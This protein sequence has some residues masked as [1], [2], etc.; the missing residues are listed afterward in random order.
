MPS[1]PG[2]E[3]S[4]RMIS[5][6]ELQQFPDEEFLGADDPVYFSYSGA[7]E[8]THLKVDIRRIVFREQQS[9]RFE[10]RC[11]QTTLR[12]IPR[13]NCRYASYKGITSM[14]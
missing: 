7:A 10:C 11:H 5:R 13:G 14:T 9:N 3:K 12:R 6:R 8:F 4:E 2:I 1:N